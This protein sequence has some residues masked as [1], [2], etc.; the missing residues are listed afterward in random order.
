MKK[1]FALLIAGFLTVFS[2]I[3]SADERPTCVFMKF[4]DD[5]RFEKVESAASLSDLV[6]EKLIASGK[7]NLQE[8]AFINVDMENLLYNFRAAEFK[9]LS[10]AINSGNFNAL[11]EGPGY[12]ENMAQSIATATQ[13]QIIL[14]EITAKIGKQHNAEYLIQGTIRNI[15]TGDWVN[16]DFQQAVVYANQAMS[17]AG[18]SALAA[19][20]PLGALAGMVSQQVA[21]FGVQ[22][23]LKV[24]KASTGEVV[25]QKVVI[26]KKTKKQ[27][28]L[29]GIKIA[30]N[31]KLDNQMYADSMNNAAQ[32]IADTLIAEVDAKKLFVK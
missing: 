16:M 8:T 2:S 15:G 30:G 19:L 22:A 6:L 29:A 20:G 14:P 11:F 32:L 3:A 31:V 25:W 13:G 28:N 5:T 17:L 24:I 4:T 1:L 26:G 21:A 7:F 18:S 9:N 12:N 10:R 27:L 23:D